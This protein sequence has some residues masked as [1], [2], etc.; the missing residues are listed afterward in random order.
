MEAGVEPQALMDDIEAFM[1]GGSG[2]A[3]G[4]GDGGAALSGGEDEPDETE[5]DGDE[6]AE[7]PEHSALL[8][9]LQR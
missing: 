3:W 5:D 9:A 7:E 2:V 4:A 1:G 6:A 8:T